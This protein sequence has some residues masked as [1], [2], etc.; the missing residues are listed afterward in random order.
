MSYRVFTSKK[1]DKSYKKCVRRAH[2]Y[3]K[4]NRGRDAYL[5]VHPPPRLHRSSSGVAENTDSGIIVFRILYFILRTL[6]FQYPLSYFVLHTLSFSSVKERGTDFS[7][8]YVRTRHSRNRPLRIWI[9]PN[10][11][12]SLESD[13]VWSRMDKLEFKCS[14][15]TFVKSI[16]WIKTTAEHL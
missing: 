3:K 16:R 11:L 15:K 13:V 14:G 1:F 6:Y 8:A 4:R 5:P 2:G 7:D 12:F 10:R 9:K